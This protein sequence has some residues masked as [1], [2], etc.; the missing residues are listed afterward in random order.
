MPTRDPVGRAIEVLMYVVE[1][2]DGPTSA[3]R[4]AAEIGIPSTT[5]QRALASLVSSDMLTSDPETQLYGPGP[6][7]HRMA[8]MATAK[9]PLSDLAIPYLQELS[10]LTGETSQ[11]GQYESTSHEMMFIAQMPGSQPLRYVVPMHSWVPL[12]LG[13]SG[14]AILAFLDDEAQQAVVRRAV[15][16]ADLD[17]K[18]LNEQLAQIRK[19]GYALSH[20]QRL[21]GAVGIAAPL[22]GRDNCVVG[23]AVLT[24]PEVQFDPAR[25]DEYARLVLDCAANISRSLGAHVEDAQAESETIEQGAPL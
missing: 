25:S 12:Y 20:G 19:D 9:H 10:H 16:E 21:P 22:R 11:I 17:E 13:A 1:H 4:I 3:R 2:S 14:L 18:K 23:D 8:R 6:S 24:V 15:V 5:V 7:L